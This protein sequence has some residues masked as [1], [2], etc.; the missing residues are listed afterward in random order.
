MRL[1]IS[2]SRNDSTSAGQHLGGD[3]ASGPSFRGHRVREHHTQ[4]RDRSSVRCPWNPCPRNPY[5][6]LELGDRVFLGT[7]IFGQKSKLLSCEI[8]GV[9]K[10][11]GKRVVS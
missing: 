9:P 5:A 1:S 11:F 10:P 4:L 8:S 6:A 3:G 2:P 7:A